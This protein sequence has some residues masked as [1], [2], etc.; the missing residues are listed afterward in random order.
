ML[1]GVATNSDARG[2]NKD[3]VLGTSFIARSMIV[4]DCGKV[5]PG[6][7]RGLWAGIL[8]S[9]PRSLNGNGREAARLTVL[10]FFCGGGGGGIS[11]ALPV[12]GV[13][14]RVV[15]GKRGTG[16]S[17]LFSCIDAG[18]CS[19]VTALA[20]FSNTFVVEFVVAE[21]AGA[22]ST[23]VGVGGPSGDRTNQAGSGCFLKT[24]SSPLSTLFL[25]SVNW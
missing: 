13:G 8:M 19:G 16:G 7:T 18:R 24:E 22:D 3:G 14:G 21:T 10:G 9:M 25:K 5:I 2:E 17:A 4:D 12:G 15:L 11:G 6:I 1:N 20:S 23:L